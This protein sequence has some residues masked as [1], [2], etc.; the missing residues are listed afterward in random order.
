MILQ[1][2]SGGP[3]FWGA[4]THLY[5]PV[6]I[7]LGWSSPEWC[8][9][10]VWGCRSM[11]G[12]VFWWCKERGVDILDI[13]IRGAYLSIGVQCFGASGAP[14]YE[15]LIFLGLGFPLG[16]PIW[17]KSPPIFWRYKGAAVLGAGCPHE[18]KEPPRGGGGVQRHLSGGQG[19]GASYREEEILAS[20]GIR[21]GGLLQDAKRRAWGGFCGGP[22]IS[23]NSRRG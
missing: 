6:A 11:W 18:S 9:L 4:L 8:Y 7:E 17:G 21:G 3:V 12:L 13:P 23:G 14:H 19:S 2:P 16:G 20:S 10:I 1:D 15:E 22:A 5:T